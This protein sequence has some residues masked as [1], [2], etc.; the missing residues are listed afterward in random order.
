MRALLDT[1][2]LLAAL[3]R[4]HPRHALARPWLARAL[5]GEITL[6]VAAHS[7]AELH[8][9]LTTLPVRPRISPQTAGRLR[10]DNL[11]GTAEI[12]ALTAD[13]YRS[14]LQ[15]VAELGLAGGVI[16][17][18]LIARAAE[19]SRVDRL[20]TL[21]ERDFRRAW[22]EGTDRITGP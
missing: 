3:V 2:V 1:S 12:V 4:A 5:A 19:S 9:T 10:D 22:P 13:D 20:V 15:R 14:V 11:P 7:L 17:D 8:A 6:V 21:N 18:A 16:Y